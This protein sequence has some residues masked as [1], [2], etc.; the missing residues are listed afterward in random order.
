MAFNVI[1]PPELE[2]FIAHKMLSGRYATVSDVIREALNLLIAQEE[3]YTRKL[4]AFNGLLSQRIEALDRGEHLK[5]T[6]VR[7]ILEEK[8][9]DRRRA[10]L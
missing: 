3:V 2:K 8:S 7:A 9:Q 6:A 10:T 4:V 5:A 1:L